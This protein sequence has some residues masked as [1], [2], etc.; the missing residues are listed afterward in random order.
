MFSQN[1][2]VFL[3]PAKSEARGT[4]KVEVVRYLSYLDENGERQSVKDADGRPVRRQYEAWVP[5]GALS[6][7]EMRTATNGRKFTFAHIDGG[8]PYVRMDN[9]FDRDGVKHSV[10]KM[11]IPSARLSPVVP[12][13]AK[14]EPEPTTDIPMHSEGMPECTFTEAD[15][16][17][18]IPFY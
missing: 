8:D 9:W 18:E 12:R 7:F 1:C 15:A 4:V 3:T 5:E 6:A 2:N 13:E 17:E 10:P 16:A 14:P 11:V